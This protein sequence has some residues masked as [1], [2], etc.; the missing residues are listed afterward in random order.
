M[1]CMLSRVLALMQAQK[2]E[3]LRRQQAQAVAAT[4]KQQMEEKK[5][6]TA[7]QN[8]TYAGKVTSD[9]FSQFG[10]SHR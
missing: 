4:L 10:T 2:A 3:A 6:R 8:E 1:Y 7:A 9:Y 5:M